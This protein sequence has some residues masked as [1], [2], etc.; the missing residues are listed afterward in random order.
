M[1]PSQSSKTKKPKIGLVLGGGAAKG[2][3]HVGFYKVLYDN[4][5][6]IDAIAG[7]SM[8][9]VVGAMIASGLTPERILESAVAFA[10]KYDGKW[11][12]KNVHLRKGGILNEENEIKTLC[13]LIPPELDFKDLKIPLAVTAVDI[14]S[15]EEVIL[16]EGNL[17]QT[18]LAS[19]ALPGIYPPIFLNNRL[20][21]D[22]GVLNNVPVNV[23]RQMNVDKVVA[24]DLK[25][26]YS[27]QNL[28]GMIYHFYRQEKFEEEYKFHLKRERFKELKMRL[29]FPLSVMMRSMNIT[30]EAL[31]KIMLE[32]NSP[33]ILVHP[34]LDPFDRFDY[35]KY[36]LIY[37]AGVDAAEAI[38]PTLKSW[39]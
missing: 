36:E 2:F 17:H 1:P 11:H 3:A 19:S 9:A 14:E 38:L 25:S 6:P 37:K 5:I 34:K 32:K 31:G 28:S 15:G 10:K 39:L 8:G 24:V 4:K 12:F 33:D 20:L 7:T 30:E 16:N 35:G 21:I 23:C 18:L 26:R 22:G 13:E 27:E 29:E